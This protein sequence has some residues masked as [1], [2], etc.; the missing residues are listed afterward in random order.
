MKTK[1]TQMRSP[2]GNPVPNQFILYTDSGTYFQSYSSIIAK[3]HNGTVTLD[4]DC[5]DYSRTTGKYRNIF[6]R[7]DKSETQRKIKQGI[8]KLE[9]LND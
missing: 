3:K 5:W 1:V 7:E 6:L 2:N 4:P 8:Y 9:N